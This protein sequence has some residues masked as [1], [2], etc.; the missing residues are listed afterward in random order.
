MMYGW[1][2]RI[3]RWPYT[4]A[5]CL[6]L[7]V[8]VAAMVASAQVGVPMKDPDGFL[9]PAYVRLPLLAL[10]IFATGIIPAALRRRSWR[11]L[12]QGVIDVVRHE[13]SLYRVFAIG[14]GLLAFY[15]CYV[16]YRNLKNVLP[17]YRDGVLFDEQLLA[18]DRWLGGGVDPA[19]LLHTIL[20]TGLTADF[21]SFIYLA[22]LPLV[23]ISL[24]FFLVCSRRISVGAW[25]AT[26]L[27]LNWVL[28]VVSYYLIPSLGPIFARP[29]LF[30]VLPETGVSDLQGALLYNRLDFLADPTMSEKI[31]GIAGFASLHVSVTFTAAL[32]MHY[33][34]QRLLMRVC[35]WAFFGL[36]MVATLY[37]GWH[38]I[39]D[40]VAG[41][42]IGWGSVAIGAWATGNTRRRRRSAEEAV[43]DAELADQDD[44]EA[45]ARPV[46]AGAAA[47]PESPVVAEAE[48]TLRD[49]R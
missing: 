18:F 14:I 19:V 21:L 23:P 20:G 17:I 27:S 25:Y 22:Y 31:H 8:G 16:G 29:D 10:L 1:M 4:F 41:M 2:T 37:F 32:F 48:S 30:R 13:W 38:Y 49:R 24:G 39:P 33:T 47:T 45:V 3:R 44:D 35:A 5:V 9:G 15:C 6:S 43:L 11:E 46:S 40:N 28:G 36:T 42:A 26:A 12:P 34:G 7:A